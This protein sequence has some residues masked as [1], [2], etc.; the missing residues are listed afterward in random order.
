MTARL[1]TATGSIY[2][3]RPPN[4]PL[5][6]SNT[7]STSPTTFDTYRRPAGARRA[8][9]TPQASARGV[10]STTDAL[11]SD[12]IEH[13]HRTTTTSITNHHLLQPPHPSTRT[14][15]GALSLPAR[16]RRDPIVCDVGHRRGGGERKHR[17]SNGTRQIRGGGRE[18]REGDVE[19]RQ[20]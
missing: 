17:S 9:K 14:R 8:R 18:T 5:Y 11:L 13:H 3:P 7:T 10:P 19:R 12:G 1:V 20:C 2:T 6:T 16:P 4:C 15:R